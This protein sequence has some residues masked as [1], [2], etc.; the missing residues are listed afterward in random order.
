[1]SHFSN[2][3]KDKG[4]K[5]QAA[6]VTLVR[7]SHQLALRGDLEDQADDHPVGVPPA[8]RR[9]ELQPSQGRRGAA[10]AILGLEVGDPPAWHRPAASHA[11]CRGEKLQ[12]SQGKGGA[13]I[14]ILG[15][16]VGDPS[17]W[18]R[19]P[20]SRPPEFL[21]RGFKSPELLRQ[22]FKSPEFLWQGCRSPEFQPQSFKSPEFLRQGFK[23][24]E[25]LRQGFKSPEFLR[26]GC[27]S[28]EFQPQG[29][30]SPEFQPVPGPP[31][32]QFGRPPDRLLLRG[33]S[34]LSR[35]PSRH[36]AQLSSGRW[37]TS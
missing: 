25:F 12:S 32:F 15:L 6:K 3:T 23:S 13:A 28:P 35:R 9:E 36:P 8:C 14:T 4:E 26:Q 30:K 1:M 2:F 17:T 21:R 24:P 31:E 34:M 18:H 16:K 27:K 29:F 22:G 5:G 7:S 20:D 19:L 11:M 10:I 33:S 37:L